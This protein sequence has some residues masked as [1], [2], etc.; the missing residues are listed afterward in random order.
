MDSRAGGEDSLRKNNQLLG[1][2]EAGKKGDEERWKG[3]GGGTA[4]KCFVLFC[5]VR[6]KGL[7]CLA[8][9]GWLPSG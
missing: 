7:P 9:A 3:G 6:G 5:V 8:F 4:K 2:A 1:A